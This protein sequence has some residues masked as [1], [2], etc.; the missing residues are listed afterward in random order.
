MPTTS[1][2]GWRGYLAGRGITVLVDDIGRSAVTR[3]DA[4][5]L[6]T[7]RRESEARQRE[8]AE[9][10]AIKADQQWRAQLSGGIPA[11]L[12]P[13]CVRPAAA[14]LQAAHDALPCRLPP[15][16]EALSN[17]GELTYHSLRSMSRDRRPPAPPRG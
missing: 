3:A 17:S 6:I 9:R 1:I 2:G 13:A 7:E 11:S 16:Q 12:I 10:Q 15:L 8:A 5:R 4:R 14:M